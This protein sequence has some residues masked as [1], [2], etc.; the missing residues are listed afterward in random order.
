MEKAGESRIHRSPYTIEK[1]LQLA[2]K[3][4]EKRHAMKVMNYAE[5]TGL[6]RA[7][8]AKELNEFYYDKTSGIDYIGRGSAKTYIKRKEE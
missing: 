5:L 1:G 4:L 7:F 3:F 2:L 8:A 6:S